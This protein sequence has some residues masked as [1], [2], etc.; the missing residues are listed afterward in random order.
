V[1]L[2]IQVME[3]HEAA[4]AGEPLP[5]P[6]DPDF[7]A[8]LQDAWE[9]T[10]E[11]ENLHIRL[12]L[13]RVLAVYEDPEILPKLT[14]FLELEDDLDPDSQIRF[15]AL[16]ALGMLADPSAV[17][18]VIPFLEHEDLY[19]R[20]A[21][22]AALQALPG[23]ESVTALKGVLD[24]PELELRGMAAISL[25]HLGDASGAHVLVDLID[26]GTYEAIR[27]EEP[28]K[29]TDARLVQNNRIRAVQALA[30]LGRPE[31]G[32]RLQ[33]LAEGD[34]DPAVRE[35]AMIALQ[36]PDRAG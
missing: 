5:W 30:R 15:G 26:P 19:L 21:A 17:P 24:A 16:E 6:Q 23:P 11:D 8:Q 9:R 4:Q 12:A 25:S 20:L 3:N 18:A 1:S 32:A 10:A 28:E 7:L 22:A 27:L 35:A 36:D 14:W 2:V 13:A 34:E 33:A 29:Y 31:D